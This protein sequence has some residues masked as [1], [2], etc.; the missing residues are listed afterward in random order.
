MLE[1]QPI[2]ISAINITIAII[3]IIPTQ[4]WRSPRPP[5]S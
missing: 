1:Q 2:A 3:V 5:A 4:L